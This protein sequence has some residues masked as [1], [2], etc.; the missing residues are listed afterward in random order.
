MKDEYMNDEYYFEKNS[1][2]IYENQWISITS[3]PLQEVAW[4]VTEYLLKVIFV[5][6]CMFAKLECNAT[7]FVQLC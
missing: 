2:R 7:G 6:S 5:K 1:Y 4:H 3:L